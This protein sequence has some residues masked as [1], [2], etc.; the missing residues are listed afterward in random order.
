VNNKLWIGKRSI[1]ENEPVYIIGEIGS[2]H[3]R[4]IKQAKQLIDIAADCG[5][6]AV[7]FQLFKTE[8]LYSSDNKLFKIFKENELP[9]EW[10][11]EIINY[12]K[13][14]GLTFLASPFDKESVDRLFKLNVVA[15]KLASSETVNLPLLGHIA[16]KHKPVLIS[17]G[18]CDLADV[19]EA[20]EVVKAAKNEQIALLHCTALY[21][22]PAEHV[23]LNAM[24]TLRSAFNLPVGFSDHTLG[25]EITFAAVAMGARIIEKHF[26]LNRQLKGPD[27]SYALEP[28]ELSALV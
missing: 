15:Y 4:K 18:M 22:T 19:Y 28:Q 27:H 2:N 26:T 12:S 23:N 10:L 6:D 11:P 3:N 5:V 24:H 14:K 21:P 7:K 9:F 25:N 8:N 16:L 17:T 13:A 20:I 1:G